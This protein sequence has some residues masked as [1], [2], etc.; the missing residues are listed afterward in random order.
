MKNRIIQISVLIISGVL[1]VLNI[2]LFGG[3]HY[4]AATLLAAFLACLP[5]YC[6]FERQ[7]YGKSKEIMMISIMTAL[8]VCGRIVFGFIPFFKPVTA[9]TIIS[10]MYLGYSAGFVTGSFSALISNIYFGHGPWTIFQMLSW[11]LIGCLAGVMGKKLENKIYI[12]IFSI[13]S[14]TIFSVIM[15]L[16]TV[17]NIDS[18]FSLS[19]Y[20]AV[21]MSGVP[22]TVT[23]S[24]SNII[25][26]LLMQKPFGRK[27]ERAKLKYG[28]FKS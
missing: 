21:F 15:D 12:I 22:V 2:L 1:A 3:K 14:G 25:F 23:Y 13:F 27:L 19:R 18:T 28:I 16:W 4:S 9:I 11:G 7:N 20:M 5:F 24:V 17:L 10:G 8:S 26:L 6:S